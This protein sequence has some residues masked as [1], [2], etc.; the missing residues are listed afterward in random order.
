MNMKEKIDNISIELIVQA[1]QLSKEDIWMQGDLE[2]QINGVKP[3][4]IVI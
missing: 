2:I 4:E 1:V 3:T